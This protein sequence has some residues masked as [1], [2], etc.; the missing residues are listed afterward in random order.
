MAKREYS[1]RKHVD[2]K[3]GWI[4]IEVYDTEC[5]KEKRDLIE[6][7]MDETLDKV[8]KVMSDYENRT[9]Q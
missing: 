4:T 7:I 5:D 8:E 1:I 3:K 6:S 2:Y 9:Q